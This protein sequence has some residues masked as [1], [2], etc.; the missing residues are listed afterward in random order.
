[1]AGAASFNILGG[2]SSIPVLFER[3]IDFKL[4]LLI[5]NVLFVRI[6]YPNFCVFG[7][8]QCHMVFEC[9]KVD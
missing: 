3:L 7:H 6:V 2:R 1:M 5:V 4:L 9:R 8:M